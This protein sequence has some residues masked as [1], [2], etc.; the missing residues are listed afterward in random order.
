MKRSPSIA[1]GFEWLALCASL[2]L[3]EACAFGASILS[4]LWPLAAFAAVV[5]F[6]VWLAFASRASRLALAFAVGFAAALFAAQS[7]R[8]VLDEAHVLGCGRPFVRELRVESGVRLTRGADCVRWAS[9]ASSA[10]SLKV[11]VIF[12]LDASAPVPQVGETWECAGW[13]ERTKVDDISLRRKLWVKGKGT[14]AR[15]IGRGRCAALLAALRA[16]LSRRMGI[17]L[18][19]DCVAADLNRAI[20]LGERA[21]MRKADRDAFAAAGTIHVFAISG[22]HVMIVAHAFAFVLALVG[23]SFRFRGVILV[24]ALWVYVAMTGASP[25]AVRAASMASL[26]FAAPFFLRKPDALVAWS[27]TFL[28]VYGTDP[29]KLFDTGCALSFAVMLGLFFWGRFVAERI[30]GRFAATLVMTF[31]AWAVGT[32]I[33]AHAFGRVT[34]GG[35]AANLLLLPAAGASVKAGIAGI[36]A[37]FVSDRLAAHVN[38]FA[39]LLSGT[40]ADVS[41]LVAA[42]PGA[43]FTVEPWPVSVCAAWYLALALLL[44]LLQ[45][46]VR[47]L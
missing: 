1:H 8:E 29:T 13:L 45:K 35:I 24:P 32:P 42:I 31:A 37:S 2:A 17:G 11:R 19:R 26:Y 16:D 25:S 7:R 43:N 40:M 20:L 41:R 30:R 46:R 28:V 22:L 9:F 44:W 34:P 27:L 36:V 10:G 5:A 33:A 4:P 39:S 23:C 38:N 21:R 3:G 18:P 14:F 47:P 6:V 12:P 15:R